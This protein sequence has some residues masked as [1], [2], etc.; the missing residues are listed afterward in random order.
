[1]KVFVTGHQGYIG[2]HLVEL[3]KAEGHQVTGCDVGLFEGCGWRDVV[4]PDKTLHKDVRQ[5]VKADI[6]GH[7]CV[8]H[9]AALSNDPMGDV[10]E[11]LTLDINRDASIALATTAKQAGVPRFLFAGSCSVYGK[12]EKLDLRESD[13]IH[14]LTAY[15]QS[16]TDT[17]TAVTALA[18]ET[19]TPAFLRNATAYGDSPMLR[20]DLMV[21]SLLGSALAYGQIRIQSDGTPW[22]P[23]IHC[24]DIARAFIAF[25]HAPSEAIRGRAVNVGGNAENYQV[26]T[27]ANHVQRLLPKAEIVYTGEVGEDSRNYRVN[28]DLLGTLLPDFQ[29]AYTVE[30]GMDEL[31]HRMRE[32][33]FDRAAFE[34][35]RFVRLRTLNRRLDRLG[36]G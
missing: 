36:A 12:G 14:P 25:A 32:F 21:N 34:G 23:L 13:P 16:K 17:E 7:D 31:L 2:A 22:R 5:L 15:A 3:L 20:I 10:N 6:E 11:K 26:R 30:T 27:V 8:M 33:G 1:M 35:D 4:A 19:F 9:L 28:F 18:D 29:L 24:R